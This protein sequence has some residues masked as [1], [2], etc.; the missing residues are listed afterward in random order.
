MILVHMLLAVFLQI[1]FRLFHLR[2]TH[3]PGVA[4]QENSVGH[5]MIN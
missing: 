2:L 1:I 5:K 3:V 4:G